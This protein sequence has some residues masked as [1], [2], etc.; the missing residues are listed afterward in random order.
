MS[1][2]SARM[3]VLAWC[4]HVRAVLAGSAAGIGCCGTV[5]VVG[6]GGD[7]A[8][9][10]PRGSGHGPVRCG[11]TR[12]LVMCCALVAGAVAG[13]LTCLGLHGLVGVRGG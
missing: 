1:P 7:G 3:V 9:G 11:W 13:P 12:A 4:V 6:A 5:V 2:G 10:V 8:V